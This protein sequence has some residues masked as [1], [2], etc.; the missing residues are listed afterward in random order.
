MKE[1]TFLQKHL[2]RGK[3]HQETQT[4]LLILPTYKKPMIFCFVTL[5][6][7]QH[8][9]YWISVYR[10]KVAMS[11]CNSFKEEMGIN[12]W[13]QTKR[14]FLRWCECTFRR[15]EDLPGYVAILSLFIHS[16]MQPGW[17]YFIHHLNAFTSHKWFPDSGR[18][19]MPC[20]IA[21]SPRFTS[22]CIIS[23]F[24]PW[25]LHQ[26]TAVKRKAESQR[27]AS[28]RATTIIWSIFTHWVPTA[29]ILQVTA[30]AMKLLMLFG[31]AKITH[32][33]WKR[34]WTIQR[35]YFG[36]KTYVLLCLGRQWS[37]PP[38][39]TITRRTLTV[40]VSDT[41]QTK[42]HKTS[43]STRMASPENTLIEK[44]VVSKQVPNRHKILNICFI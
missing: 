39:L 1:Y 14:S 38:T 6:H 5:N 13:K 18:R 24:V 40:V 31:S 16:F 10:S 12:S 42:G 20:W 7:V 28:L 4:M 29:G 25:K 3:L 11:A 22:S 27:V 35:K 2:W 26:N 15:P 36:T 8:S 21:S 41:E 43:L 37:R 19:F 23:S 34:P 33:V 9:Q 32:C 44:A 17:W 30:C